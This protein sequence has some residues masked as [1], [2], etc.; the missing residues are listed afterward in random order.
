MTRTRLLFVLAVCLLLVWVGIKGWRI[1]QATRALLAQQSQAESLLVNGITGVNPDEVEE[2]VLEMRE[3]VQVLQRETAVFMPLL[4]HMEWIPRYGPTLAAAPQLM[5]IADAGTETA[6]YLTQG[7]K[8][9][10]IAL[11]SPDTTDRIPA[12]VTAIDNATPQISLARQSLARARQARTEIQDTTA[13]SWRVQQLLTLMDKWLPMAEDGLQLA[14]ILPE[15]MGK[16]GR[17][18]Y[19][20]I[21]QNEDELRP[22]GGF[23]TGAG[24]MVVENG[25]LLDL[26]F[27]DSY[28]VDNW[29]AKPYDL[30]PPPLLEFMGLELFLFRDANFWPDFPTSAEKAIQLYQY[31]QNFGPI[32]GVIAIDQQFVRLLVEA[33][34]PITVEDGTTITGQNAITSLQNA[35]AIVDGQIGARKN[36]M[37]QFATAIRT[38]IESDFGSIDPITLAENMFTAAHQKHLQIYM[39]DPDIQAIFDQLGWTGRMTIPTGED[40][41]A[42]VD[43]NM[44][45]NKANLFIEQ[46]IAYTVSL[47]NDGQATADLN[48]TYTHTLSKPDAACLQGITYDEDPVYLE[49]AEHCYWNYVRVYAPT[50]SVL[51]EAS[52]HVVPA[53]SMTTGQAWAGKAVTLQERPDAVTFA[54]FMLVSFAETET[55]HFRYKLPGVIT[56]LDNGRFQYRLTL[57]KQAGTKP[58]PVHVTVNLPDTAVLQTATPTPTQINGRTLHFDLTLETDTV[59]EIVFSQ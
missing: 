14:E 20:L 31:G 24:I 1:L 25:R 23:I 38:K 4:S 51:Q 3:N 12:L 11:Q 43:T 42:V 28:N 36:F 56:Q 49:V 18:H 30:P 59:L 27:G 13:L 52:E 44:G 9:A 21:A 32:D 15:I 53:E 58:I 39:R 26:S 41:L 22:T 45:F 19:L 57:F 37:G 16:N 17:R 33:T 6:V 10:L 34:G 48:L 46:T 50:G 55:S 7:L 47:T 35:W 8:P 29:Q 2:M 40:F 54:N 5:A